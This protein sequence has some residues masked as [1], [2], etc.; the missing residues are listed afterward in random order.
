MIFNF[1]K[2]ETT[3]LENGNS[4]HEAGDYAATLIFLMLGI[5][6]GAKGGPRNANCFA[7]DVYRHRVFATP[8][9]H[10]T[11][12]KNIEASCRSITRQWETEDLAA[13]GGEEE[14]F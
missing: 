9:S 1:S 11:M 10:K 3:S 2:T 5:H 7:V 4:R 12:L 13:N 6:F 14:I 8:G